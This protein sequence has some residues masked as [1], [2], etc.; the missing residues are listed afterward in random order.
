MYVCTYAYLT[1]ICPICIYVCMYVYMYVCMYV[2]MYVF[3]CQGLP[4]CSREV[5]VHVCMFVRMFQTFAWREPL[6]RDD[7]CMTQWYVCVCMYISE[8]SYGVNLYYKK[9]NV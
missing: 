4:A 6:L 5:Y 1:Y 2:C 3:V 8:F 7:E 9:M